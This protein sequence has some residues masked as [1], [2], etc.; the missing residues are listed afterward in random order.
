MLGGR[1]VSG[2][3][4]KLCPVRA[5]SPQFGRV[6]VRPRAQAQVDN[7]KLDGDVFR[8]SVNGAVHGLEPT[9]FAR[10]ANPL[11][12]ISGTMGGH[13]AKGDRLSRVPWQP[14]RA[15]AK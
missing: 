15:H 8:C 12:E 1:F 9:R 10:A 11:I 4:Q 5:G 7:R 6:A 13:R 3:G 2:E 14:L